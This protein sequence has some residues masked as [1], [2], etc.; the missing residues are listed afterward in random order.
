[1]EYFYSQPTGKREKPWLPLPWPRSPTRLLPSAPLSVLPSLSSVWLSLPRGLLKWFSEGTGVRPQL[2]KLMPSLCPYH[3][4]ALHGALHSWAS[5]LPGRTESPGRPSG[6]P[7]PHSKVTPVASWLTRWIHKGVG[8]A[9]D[10][11]H[12]YSSNRHLFLSHE[13]VLEHPSRGPSVPR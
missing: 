12:C 9:R 2:P 3:L 1:M 11:P 7:R 13:T 4:E 5:F 6:S 8:A 10:S